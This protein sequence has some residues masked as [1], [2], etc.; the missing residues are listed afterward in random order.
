MMK[1]NKLK[2]NLGKLIVP[3]LALVLVAIFGCAAMQDIIIPAYISPAAI[4]YNDANDTSGAK[5]F[6]PW[7]TLWDAKRLAKQM[8]R[9]S[10]LNQRDL[11]RLLVDDASLYTFLAGDMLLN[12]RNAEELKSNVFSPTSPI[13]M[14][15]AAGPAFAMGIYGFSKPKDKK[16]IRELEKTVNPTL[17]E[18]TATNWVSNP[19]TEEG[20]TNSTVS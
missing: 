16:V 19:S 14:L 18:V 7:T 5:S 12:I 8:Q 6:V 20:G 13:G 17:S 15:L 4:E 1:V 11:G 3:F 10:E 9:K 2:P